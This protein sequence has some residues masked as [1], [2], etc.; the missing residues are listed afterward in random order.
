MTNVSKRH[1]QVRQER[2]R[3]VTVA[4]YRWLA[5]AI[6]TRSGDESDFLRAVGV[7]SCRGRAAAWAALA[8]FKAQEYQR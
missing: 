4:A 8:G 5:A 3:L 1:L 6:V 2:G 7:I